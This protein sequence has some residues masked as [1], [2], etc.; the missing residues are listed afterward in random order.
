[1]VFDRVTTKVTRAGRSVVSFLPSL[2][3]LFTPHL[4]TESLLCRRHHARCQGCDNEQKGGQPLSLGRLLWNALRLLS[5]G[6]RDKMEQHRLTCNATGGAVIY[7]LGGQSLWR[8]ATGSGVF[9]PGHWPRARL[10]HPLC[11]SHT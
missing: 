5:W 3:P 11:T 1:M 4:F 7:G 10:T 8:C 9:H 2:L 6:P